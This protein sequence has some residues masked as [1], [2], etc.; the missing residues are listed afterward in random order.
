MS[1]WKLYAIN[2]LSEA[3]KAELANEINE[4]SSLLYLREE[5][6]GAQIIVIGDSDAARE[7]LK[8]CGRAL[9]GARNA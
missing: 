2:P 4:A 6:T 9:N 8:T 5:T 1:N 7:A 3:H